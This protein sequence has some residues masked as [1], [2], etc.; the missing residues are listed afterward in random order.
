L[1]RLL[2]TQR[3]LS[4]QEAIPAGSDVRPKVVEALVSA[5]ERR[6]EEQAAFAGR[7]ALPVP[8]EPAR[9]RLLPWRR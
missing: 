9:R 5:I 4:V 8:E 1:L 7:P 6:L 2:G 3:R